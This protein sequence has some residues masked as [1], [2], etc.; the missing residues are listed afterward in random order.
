MCEHVPQTKPKP[1]V[2]LTL[3]IEIS[4]GKNSGFRYFLRALDLPETNQRCHDFLTL[5]LQ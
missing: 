1:H 5:V 4:L 2:R 3:A